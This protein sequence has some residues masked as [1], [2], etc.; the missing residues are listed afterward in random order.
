MDERALD[1]FLPVGE[2]ALRYRRG[3]TRRCARCDPAPDRRPAPRRS[4]WPCAASSSSS[5]ESPSE[6]LKRRRLGELDLRR[7]LHTLIACRPAASVASTS[8]CSPRV[9]VAGHLLR[10]AELAQQLDPVRALGRQERGRPAEE[11][12]GCRRVCAL[13][14]ADPGRR[15]PL[16]GPR[17]EPRKLRIARPKLAP[18]SVRLLRVVP[19]ELVG[20]A[21]VLQ[22]GAVPLVEVRA[23][24][25]RDSRVGDVADENV[26]EAKLVLRGPR[27][28]A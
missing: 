12:D 1:R 16:A 24:L 22:P 27:R 2:P 17:C 15:E 26:V 6:S 4:E 28:R 19:D 7:R 23:A 18:V 25:F 21:A 9:E 14:C 3:C 11:V 20:L 8:V 13:P 5:A 10:H